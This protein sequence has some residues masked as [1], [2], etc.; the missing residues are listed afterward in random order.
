MVTF[1]GLTHAGLYVILET[2]AIGIAFEVY[3][4]EKY[5]CHD[6]FDIT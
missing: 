6:T 5:D 4:K 1:W 2:L 3:E